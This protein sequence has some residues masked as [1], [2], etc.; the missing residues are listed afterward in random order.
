MVKCASEYCPL[1][2]ES[3]QYDLTVSSIIY[4]SLREFNAL[5]EQPSVSFEEWRTQSVKIWI[6]YSQLEYPLIEE[7]PAV[8]LANLIS[9]IGGTMSIIISVSFF[10]ILEICELSVI[11]LLALIRQ[12]K[13]K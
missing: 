11:L 9:S 3:V 8:T 10:T 13:R 1:E 4:P 12:I 2:C 5:S 6:Y 7:T